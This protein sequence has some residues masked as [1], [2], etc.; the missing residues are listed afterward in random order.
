MTTQA[1][2]DTYEDHLAVLVVG[3]GDLV[4]LLGCIDASII[5][6]KLIRRHAL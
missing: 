3:N 2:N 6:I 5:V 4:A 1:M